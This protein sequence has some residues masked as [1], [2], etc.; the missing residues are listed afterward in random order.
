MKEG[1][2]NKKYTCGLKRP[3]GVCAMDI[4]DILSG[5][6][7]TDEDKQHFLPFQA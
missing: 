4:S 2:N 7:E 1:D 5:R 3:F 6:I